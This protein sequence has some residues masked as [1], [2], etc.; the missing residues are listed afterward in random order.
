MKRGMEIMTLMTN[1]E[2]HWWQ[3]ASITLKFTDS[4]FQLHITQFGQIPYELGKKSGDRKGISRPDSAHCCL[5]SSDWLA[6]I[7]N[8]VFMLC[9]QAVI[10]ARRDD[11]KCP[12]SIFLS[13][14][15]AVCV[16]VYRPNCVQ[17]LPGWFQM[18]Q[19]KPACFAGCLGGMWERCW[20]GEGNLTLSVCVFADIYSPVCTKS[21]LYAV[22]SAGEWIVRT[23]TVMIYSSRQFF[24]L[25]H[26][27]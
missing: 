4:L 17:V 10:H 13:P 12:Q 16:C 22:W 7:M 5:I 8:G 21:A 27:D 25:I 18:T 19:K 24:S 3:K 15:P 20:K 9:I 23:A 1:W 14:K 26:G 11:R 2:T 6:D